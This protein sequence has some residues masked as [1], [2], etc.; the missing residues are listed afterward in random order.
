MH[1]RYEVEARNFV[2]GS[3][4]SGARPQ[5]PPRRRAWLVIP[6]LVLV[7]LAAAAGC[8]GKGTSGGVSESGGS[9]DTAGEATLGVPVYPGAVEEDSAMEMRHP[10]GAEG[11]ERPEPPE[12]SS[13]P[14]GSAPI[15]RDGEGETSVPPEDSAGRIRPTV[16][17]TADSFEKVVRWYR[18]ELSGRDGFSEASP[19]EP[20]GTDDAGQ[21]VMFTF[22]SEDATRSV[23]IS[24]VTMDR[25][26]TA[27]MV[28]AD[29]GGPPGGPPTDR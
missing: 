6:V 2:I 11:G 16:L 8:G 3:P 28:G 15:P 5:S 13:S 18:D 19:A 24:A 10:G 20:E 7:V 21:R 1:S 14:S 22:E 9:T 27:I 12:G 4:R 25:G 29:M 23:V 26:G 17:W